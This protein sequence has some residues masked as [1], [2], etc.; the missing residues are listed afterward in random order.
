MSQVLFMGD[1][2]D[3]NKS[4]LFSSLQSVIVASPCLGMNF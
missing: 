2:T 3:S 1:N 4:V